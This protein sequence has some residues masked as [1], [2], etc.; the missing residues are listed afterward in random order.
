MNRSLTDRGKDKIHIEAWIRM[1]TSVS[2]LRIFGCVAY[3]YV[4]EGVR[5]KLKK[6]KIHICWI[7]CIFQSLQTIQFYHKEGNHSKRCEIYLI[8]ILD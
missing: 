7:E 6:W 5:K 1:K 4:P 3:A 8:S 2:H